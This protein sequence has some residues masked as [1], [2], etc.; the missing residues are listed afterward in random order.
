MVWQC[1]NEE[2]DKMSFMW[3]KLTLIHSYLDN[4]CVA[5]NLENNSR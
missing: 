4:L 1:I 3:M 5:C 2:R